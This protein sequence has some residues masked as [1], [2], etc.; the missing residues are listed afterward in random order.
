MGSRRFGRVKIHTPCSVCGSHSA[1]RTRRTAG[2]RGRR[3]SGPRR[4]CSRRLVPRARSGCI[5]SARDRHLAGSRSH[6]GR[7]GH[8]ARRLRWRHQVRRRAASSRGRPPGCRAAH[9]GDARALEG[10]GPVGSEGREGREAPDGVEFEMSDR[11]KTLRVR[12][13]APA[14]RTCTLLVQWNRVAKPRAETVDHFLGSFE[15]RKP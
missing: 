5:P 6:R 9:R 14:G 8:P 10:A 13:V 11:Q 1:C 15:P 4:H 3:R 2:A 12:V 7:R